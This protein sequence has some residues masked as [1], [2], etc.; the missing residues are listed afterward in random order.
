MKLSTGQISQFLQKPDPSVRVALIYGPDAGLV[1]E[2]ADFLAKQIAPDPND[3]FCTALLPGTAIAEDP[4]RLADEMNAQ[5]L[6]GGRRLVRLQQATDTIAAALG[7][8]LDDAKDGDSLLLIEAGDLEKRSKLRALCEGA[9][10]IAC[11]IPCYVEDGPQ[12]QRAIADILQQAG[13]TAPRDVILFL[14]DTLP[15][16]RLAMRSELGKLVLYAGAARAI[17]LADARAA[18]GDGGA[19]EI[20]DLVYAA[21]GGEGKRAMLLLDRLLGEQTAPVAIA[22]A[23][24]RHVMK[25]SLAKG[26]MDA[27]A[28]ASEA[29]AKLQPPVFWK[30][31]DALAAQLRRWPQVRIENALAKLFETEAALKRTGAPDQSLCAQA[32]LGIAA[33]PDKRSA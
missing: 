25:L 9:N 33:A 14:A 30:Y 15:P 32:V 6:G 2:R 28:S 5:A 22:R 27:G 12:R 24:Q 17:T 3:P 29:V 20:D 19:A 8:F 21:G 7:S 18:I 23:L 31:K 16:D 11:A 26:Y 1:K 4:A 13:L 10:K